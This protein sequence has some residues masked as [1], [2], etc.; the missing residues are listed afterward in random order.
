MSDNQ[1]NPLLVTLK[2]R[3]PGGAF[4]LPSQG[5]FYTNG[6]ISDDVKH[7]EIQVLPMTAMDEILIKTP[8]KLMSGKAIEEV[9]ARCVPQVL[10]PFDMLSKD[11]D[12]LLM[13][14]RY[15]SY[16]QTMKLQYKHNCEKA[17]E[18]EYDINLLPLIKAARRIN[19]TTIDSNFGL[20]LPNDQVVK[21][22]PPL[23]ASVLALYMSNFEQHNLTSYDETTA[24][25][26]L[27]DVVVSTIESVDGITDKQ[28][29]TQWV[30]EI[31]VGY[32]SLIGNIMQN[33][34]DWGA[35]S[36]TEVICKDCGEHLTMEIPL[37]P[38]A[39]FF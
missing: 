27:F 13:C 34:S 28:L 9:F 11:I 20:T 31:P 3:L 7:G 5:I 21:L 16:G 24:Q 37:N 8:D 32:M 15:V 22:R 26:K 17:K 23:F 14:I 33:V 38:V 36:T 29:I 1:L 19:A 10:K 6:E 12:F 18:H 30:K 2:A 35:S 25:L 39:F 4:T